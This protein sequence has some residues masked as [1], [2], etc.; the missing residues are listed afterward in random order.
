MKKSLSL[1]LKKA[2]PYLLIVL[3]FIVIAYAYTPEVLSG[4]IVDQ[5]DIAGWKGMANE[6]VTYNEEHPD[7]PTLWTNSMFGGMPANIISVK[8]KGDYT[9]PIYNALFI[10]ARPASYLIIS[11]IGGFL[12]F[13]AFG[14]NIWLSAVGA[15]AITFCS[16]NM[17]I[18]QVGHNTKMIAIA[19]MPWVLAAIVHA[20]RKAP[21]W[22]SLL[23]A[24]ALS[25]QIKANHPQITYYLAM[26]VLAF[27]IAQF[28]IELKNKTLP[29]FIK[30]SA[31][32][33][34]AGLLGI[35]TNINHLWPTYEYQAYSMRG[36]SELTNDQDVQSGKGLKKDYATSWSYGIEETPNLLIPNFNGGA[37]VGELSTKSHTYE[38]LRG[39][40]GANQMIKQM[41]LYWGPQPFT[42]GPMYMGAISIFLFVLGLCLFKGATKWWIAGISLVAVLLSWGSH[43]MFF[44][45][46]FFRFAPLYNKFRTV[47]MILVILQITIPVLGILTFNKI[48]RGEYEKDKFRRG[49]YI[50][51]AVT[52]GFSL[53]M[54]L[55]PSLAGHFI[56]PYDSGYPNEVARALM[57]DR[58][59]LLRSDAIRSLIFIA[60]S[61]CVV[62]FAWNKKLK[63][64]PATII[65]GVLILGDLWFVDKRYLNNSHFINKN[66]FE[67]Q[68]TPR[69][70]DEFI[71]RDNDPDYRVV[72]LSV[73]TFN[74]A[75]VSYYHK[76]IG[77]Y[78]AAKLQRYQDIIDFY[79]SDEL[80]SIRDFI[81]N[82]EAETIG[83]LEDNLSYYPILS[84]LNT[85]YIIIGANNPPIEN[86]FALGNAW[87]VENI[88][89]ATNA[90][91]E[92]A[93]L[94]TIDPATTAVIQGEFSGAVGQIEEDEYINLVSYSPN[95]LI[96][97]YKANSPKMALF[98]E[99][100]YPT[101][102][103]ATVD[104]EEYDLLRA[105][106]I[107]RAMEL[108][109]GEHEIELYF[110][111]ESFRKGATMSRIGS[112][113][114]LLLLL[115]GIGGSLRR[116]GGRN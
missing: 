36:G 28:I 40:S 10:G 45:N 66:R 109:E 61:A 25:F 115:G 62:W 63:A 31:L 71:L 75:S 72:D 22:G 88:V 56:T 44:S 18:M 8:Y 65:L 99:V 70:V 112:I 23:F 104:G 41:P 103:T 79:L 74:D 33:L 92:I 12:L 24:F 80:A 101:G 58:M 2:L 84:M 89:S 87:F 43:L 19:F 47:S 14:V 15:I 39:Y 32:L 3:G 34:V 102:W 78:S 68:F 35:M 110:Q 29:R 1:N 111:P 4:K 77:G 96:Y 82:S 21:F 100:Y 52:A 42:A 98:S 30:I 85:K 113:T 105:N 76:N 13:L 9:D 81:N 93:L 91:E 55:I 86:N 11:L 6:I 114:L 54:A 38:A 64:I 59:G 95:R 51:L 73:S 106:Y 107:L 116:R 49:F 46:I 67:S 17:Q 94:G 108:P 57:Q 26:I 7:D 53:I 50:A 27:V 37:S 5:S 16:Y 69:P 97:T 83:D 48:L 60:L 20:Y 90:D